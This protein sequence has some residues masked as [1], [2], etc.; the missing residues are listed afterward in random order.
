V[1]PSKPSNFLDML[2]HRGEKLR[3]QLALA[4]YSD[5]TD[6]CSS[7]PPISTTATSDGTGLNSFG[8]RAA[9]GMTHDD[10]L[11]TDP[12]NDS[13]P[14]GL[15]SG[16]SEEDGCAHGAAW[17]MNQTLTSEA[18]GPVLDDD[19]LEE[20]FYKD[21]NG[22]SHDDDPGIDSDDDEVVRGRFTTTTPHL[23]TSTAVGDDTAVNGGRSHGHRAKRDNTSINVAEITIHKFVRNDS[24]PA[25]SPAAVASKGATFV[26]R[27]DMPEELRRTL[28]LAPAVRA[29]SHPS[30]GSIA[31]FNHTTVVP[32]DW[33]E[34]RSA[35]EAWGSCSLSFSV[36]VRSNH[37][38]LATV[39]HA[40]LRLEDVLAAEDF[41]LLKDL[42]V[43]SDS[44][45][46]GTEGLVGESP[47]PPIGRLQVS[48]RFLHNGAPSKSGKPGVEMQADG[49]EA[50]DQHQHTEFGGG[51]E[52]GDGTGDEGGASTVAVQLVLQIAKAKGIKPRASD[53]KA[54]NI[55][56]A[57][58]TVSSRHRSH[59]KGC[60][61][62]TYHL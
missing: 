39:G 30:N 4:A 43:W 59:K 58:R 60:G 28:S 48:L 40:F 20:L 13:L 7:V 35:L 21:S 41:T 25:T 32:V 12:L 22:R 8:H 10:D 27:S 31:N 42:E 61:Q 47:T 3:D 14:V 44:V 37:G 2:L 15:D 51:V 24:T 55:F 17:M 52:G 49:L 6:H 57:C 50:H 33:Q 53:G 62:Q 36:L 45:V 23:A 56:L 9:F 46:E 38:P 18:S 11:L 16:L 5:G 34:K 54:P 26:V 29:S 1:K 19:I